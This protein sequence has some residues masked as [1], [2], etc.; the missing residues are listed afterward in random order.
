MSGESPLP[1]PEELLRLNHALDA[2]LRQLVKVEQRLFLSQRDRARQIAR[3]DALNRFA[4]DATELVTPHEVV[5]RAADVLFALFPFD[6]FLGFLTD[7]EPAGQLRCVSVRAVEGRDGP[8]HAS[9]DELAPIDA[10]D[11]TDARLGTEEEMRARLPAL[12]GCF[13][14]VFPSETPVPKAPM[15]V[16]PL[17]YKTE[18]PLGLLVF[19][20]LD[21]AISFHEELPTEKDYAFL[22]V[23]AQQVA[24]TVANAQLVHDLKISLEQL[25][26]AQASLVDRERLAAL[27][28]FAAVIAHEVRNP[29]GVI[30]NVLSMLRRIE[31]SPEASA[32]VD[33]LGE[34]S[35][36]LNQIVSDLIDF[37]RPH[38]PKLGRASMRRVVGSAV[39]SVRATFPTREIQVIE[40]TEL[41]DVLVDAHMIRQALVNL[42]VN[43]V[44][45]SPEDA[46]VLVRVV[47]ENGRLDVAVVDRG[48]GIPQPLIARIFEPFFTTKAAG[49]GLGL[50]V[51]KRVVE[52]HRGE[53]LLA[54]APGQ[55]STFTLRL[56][57]G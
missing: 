10:V 49:T 53:L 2:Q 28:E 56:P 8:V 55:G 40:P 45:A 35:E 18:R 24:A 47:V 13:E 32:L 41:P 31:S 23:V 44:Q 37:A 52:A 25:A 57:I 50:S 54:S 12:V 39:E 5:A 26:T 30:F 42:L 34:E 33:I 6:Q 43:A 11:S 4:L 38:P 22:G 1:D 14:R 15:L 19:R 46:S 9:L 27:G 7:E 3:L 51:V 21:R 48:A 17:A 36:R 20:R 16:V 29:L